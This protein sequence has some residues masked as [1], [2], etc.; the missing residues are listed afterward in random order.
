MRIK[1]PK[2]TSNTT[3]LSISFTKE[4][5]SYEVNPERL[6]RK[7]SSR[8]KEILIVWDIFH[9]IFCFVVHARNFAQLFTKHSE[10]YGEVN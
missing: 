6:L 9:V 2:P 7:G 1:I 10:L 3:S 4:N 8:K 5:S